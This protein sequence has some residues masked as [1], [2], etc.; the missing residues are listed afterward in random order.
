MTLKRG[1]VLL[2]ASSYM[3]QVEQ[4]NVKWKIYADSSQLLLTLA[5]P[6]RPAQKN[7]THMALFN[8]GCLS[9]Y[10]VP[11]VPVAN[12]RRQRCLSSAMGSRG[13]LV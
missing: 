4:P 9:G 8:D 11:R 13:I 7:D 3:K 2:K 5:V 10:R 12:W 6:F 1:T